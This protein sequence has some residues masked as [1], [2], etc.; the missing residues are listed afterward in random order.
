[1]VF[2]SDTSVKRAMSCGRGV[3]REGTRFFGNYFFFRIFVDAEDA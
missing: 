2:D 1:M 3:V